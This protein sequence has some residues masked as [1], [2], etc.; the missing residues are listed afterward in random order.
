MPTLWRVL[1]YALS[2]YHPWFDGGVPEWA[3]LPNSVG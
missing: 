2:I 1:P 3:G